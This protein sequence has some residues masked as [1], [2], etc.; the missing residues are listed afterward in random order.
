MNSPLR[1]LSQDYDCEGIWW[2]ISKPTVKLPGILRVRPEDI[3]LVILAEN[4]TLGDESEIVCGTVNGAFVTLLGCTLL[5]ECTSNFLFTRSTYVIDYALS[6][7]HLT[8]QSK[9][10][11]VY[12]TFSGMENSTFK[13]MIEVIHKGDAIQ[14]IVEAPVS[15]SIE[16]GD[17]SVELKNWVSSQHSVY[18][19]NF[20]EKFSFVIA[21]VEAQDFDWFRE[22]IFQLR[23]LITVLHGEAILFQQL[24]LTFSDDVIV[25]V[26]FEQSHAPRQKLQGRKRIFIPIRQLEREKFEEI[27]KAWF[28]DFRDKQ[29][30]VQ[31]FCRL[32]YHP[33]EHP[34]ADLVLYCQMLE[35]FHRTFY[36]GQYMDIDDYEPHLQKMVASIP[37]ELE[38]SLKAR[39]K[40]SLRF[41][42]QFSQRKRFDLLMNE[43]PEQFRNALTS[44]PGDFVS[45]VLDTRNFYT[46]SDEASLSEQ[47]LS[48]ED[49]PLVNFALSAWFNF[50]LLKQLGVPEPLLL[51]RLT[52]NN[53]FSKYSGFKHY[54]K[55]V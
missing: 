45:R 46:H 39:I 12:V 14:Q 9:Y 5:D 8:E 29:L 53:A 52:Q 28:V 11:N 25:N 21:P 51:A 33:N 32:F 42:Y 48:D 27:L 54:L 13:K 4:M 24:S 34:K 15:H 43:I 6:G 31:L 44:K 40:S 36:G 18:K 49:V 23:D 38:S 19:S 47:V 50:L 20:E 3:T 37:N 26:Y 16:I 2:D 55:F 30:S 10:L 35:A 1:N 17:F 22:K 41:G 7:G